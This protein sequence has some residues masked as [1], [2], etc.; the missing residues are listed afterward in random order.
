MENESY[1]KLYYHAFN[2]L[3]DLAKEIERT[4]N[5]LEEMYLEAGEHLDDSTDQ[6]K[7]RSARRGAPVRL[8]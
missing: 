5:E 1:K 7:S 3:T 2:R 8:L 6:Q 4:Q